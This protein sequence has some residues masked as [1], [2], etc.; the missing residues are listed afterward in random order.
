MFASDTI[1][2]FGTGITSI[3]ASILVFRETGSALSVGLMLMATALPGLFFGL[4]AGVYVDRLDRKRIMLASEILRM[5]IIAAI[6]FLI[7]YGI[8]WLYLLVML[9]STVKQFFEPAHASVLP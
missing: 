4:I 8:W 3:A 1:S 9:A 6:P 5:V 2:E 7:T